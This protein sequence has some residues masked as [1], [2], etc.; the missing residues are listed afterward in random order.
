MAMVQAIGNLFFNCGN[1]GEE[2]EVCSSQDDGADGGV[3]VD[4]PA[5]TRH[6]QFDETIDQVRHYVRIST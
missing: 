6:V 4:P 1:F 5:A 3:E 2:N